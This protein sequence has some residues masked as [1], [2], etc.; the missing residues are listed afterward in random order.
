MEQVPRELRVDVRLFI[1]GGLAILK[2]MRRVDFNVWR[3]RPTV[4]RWK[5]LRLLARVWLRGARS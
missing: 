1:D 3:K 5:K 4:S 2:A